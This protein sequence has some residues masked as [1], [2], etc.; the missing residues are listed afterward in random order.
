MSEEGW[1]VSDLG[2]PD[3]SI[4][5]AALGEEATGATTGLNT[6]TASPCE[7]GCPCYCNPP[8]QHVQR[9]EEETNL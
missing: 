3:S 7:S 1:Q 6:V 5:Q 2:K 8:Q 9:A 4:G